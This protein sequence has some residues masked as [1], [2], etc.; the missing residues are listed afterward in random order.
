[1][2]AIPNR[3]YYLRYR[4]AVP[5]RYWNDITD[6]TRYRRALRSRIR[7][8]FI[9]DALIST[10]FI[11]VDCGPPGEE[12]LLFE[13]M[14]FSDIESISGYQVRCATH[15]QALAQHWH[16]VTLYKQTLNGDR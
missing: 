1:M 15:R 10:V 2:P 8:T 14:I 13:T 11:G 16:A 7:R 3:L 12:P 6:R 4:T 9:G 5:Y